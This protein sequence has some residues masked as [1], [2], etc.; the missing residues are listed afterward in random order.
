[1]FAIHVSPSIGRIVCPARADA[2]KRTAPPPMTPKPLT[3]KKIDYKLGTFEFDGKN[4]YLLG[5]QTC[6]W[7]KQEV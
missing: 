5:S 7:R 4:I 6:K 3:A 1:M 2:V